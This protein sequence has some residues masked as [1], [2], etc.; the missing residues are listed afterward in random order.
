M[1][2]EKKTGTGDMTAVFTRELEF[3]MREEL[4]IADITPEVAAALA[5]SGINDG[6]VTIFVPG[7][8][9]VVTC[10]EYEPGVLDDFREAIER[11]MPRDAEYQHNVF[12]TD[13]NGHAHVRAGMLG[14]SLAVP[15]TGGAMTLGVWQQIVLVNCDNRARA[16]RVV[17][18]V[19]GV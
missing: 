13:G 3:S 15:V 14:P 17:V 19:V 2:A 11:L 8:T 1:T 18:K 9:G 6:I 12:Q 4:D 7:A 10:L 5:D 16:R